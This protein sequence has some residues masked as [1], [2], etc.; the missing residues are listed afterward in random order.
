M[1]FP[2]P[3][4]RRDAAGR[5]IPHEFVILGPQSERL[6]SLEVG[7]EWVWLRVAKVYARVWDADR[8]PLSEELRFV[9]LE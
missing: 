2:D 5:I 9:D 3:E 1:R 4:S 8:P 7:R 6:Q